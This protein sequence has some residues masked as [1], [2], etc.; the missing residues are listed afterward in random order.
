MTLAFLI[1][2]TCQD[3]GHRPRCSLLPHAG[4]ERNL[5]KVVCLGTKPLIRVHP[6]PVPT[7]AVQQPTATATMCFHPERVTLTHL[8]LSHFSYPTSTELILEANFIARHCNLREESSP[9]TNI[10]CNITISSY[11]PPPSLVTS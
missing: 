8:P 3:I 7:K 6:C 5:D 11:I 2:A 4:M 9:P 1:H 10:L